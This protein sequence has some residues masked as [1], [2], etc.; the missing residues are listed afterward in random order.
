MDKEELIQKVIFEA[1]KKDIDRAFISD[2]LSEHYPSE[3]GIPEG[4][5][6]FAEMHQLL[7]LIEAAE[8]AH[9][10]DKVRCE[11]SI[12]GLIYSLSVIDGKKKKIDIFKVKKD[13]EI[14]DLFK[15]YNI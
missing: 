6:K 9:A 3:E 15:K 10:N 12:K 13:F 7:S 1:D 2:W 14:D 8:I 4:F 5:D 11:D